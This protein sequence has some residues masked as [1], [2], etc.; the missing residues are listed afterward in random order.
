MPSLTT[1]NFFHFSSG[2]PKEAQNALASL[3]REKDR[4][5]ATGIKVVPQMFSYI[6]PLYELSL[7]AGAGDLL[8]AL[9]QSALCFL[10]GE[11][12]AG[13]LQDP[14]NKEMRDALSIEL[15]LTAAATGTSTV[16]PFTPEE[17]RAL[18]DTETDTYD[19]LYEQAALFSTLRYIITAPDSAS[20][21]PWLTNQLYLQS[22][23]T[24]QEDY[25]WQAAYF[26]AL[27]LR[28]A[29]ATFP[30]LALDDQKLLIQNL[31]Y[32]SV[33]GHVPVRAIMQTIF[34]TAET[35]TDR[36][37]LNELFIESIQSNQE[38]VP[39]T[40]ATGDGKPLSNLIQ[41][42]VQRGTADGFAQEQLLSEWY[43]TQAGR[44]SYVGWLREIISIAM[45][46]QNREWTTQQA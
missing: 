15:L 1:H 46:V 11:V 9:D 28:A 20:Y 34:T 36:E 23:T 2:T 44:D 19:E 32:L 6:E 22:G 4:L 12:V 7:R 8:L 16:T 10:E 5:M 37:Q 26:T 14:N 29:W 30:L 40:L 39:I 38:V 43:G 27:L 41:I 17:L 24:G 18:E 25:D 42:A 13:F 31:L 3:T 35:D 45:R 33:V 21:V